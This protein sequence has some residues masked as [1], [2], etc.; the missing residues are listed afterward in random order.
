MNRYVNIET[1]NHDTFTYI[2]LIQERVDVYK[3]HL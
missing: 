2:A 1:L 3:R